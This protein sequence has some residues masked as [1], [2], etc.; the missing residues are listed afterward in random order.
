M[1]AAGQR[2]ALDPSHSESVDLPCDHSTSVVTPRAGS[3]LDYG[4]QISISSGGDAVTSGSTSGSSPV[5]EAPDE[6][7]DESL[8]IV[9]EKPLFADLEPN[10][11]IESV[12]T[13]I[14]D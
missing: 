7:K 2:F 8:Q 11:P 5:I 13:E 12:K 3:H 1:V 9:Q 14:Q 10:D 4:E 6:I